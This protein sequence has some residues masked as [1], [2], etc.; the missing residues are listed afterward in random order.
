MAHRKRRLLVG[1]WIPESDLVATEVLNNNTWLF[2]E[3]LF[4]GK[5]Q[6]LYRCS[7]AERFVVTDH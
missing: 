5:Q 3:Q 1:F 4:Y 2:L 6:Y 7:K